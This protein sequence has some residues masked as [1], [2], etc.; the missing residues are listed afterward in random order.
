M[1]E[2]YVPVTAPRRFNGVSGT[3]YWLTPTSSEP[4]ISQDQPNPIIA[5]LVDGAVSAANDK[6]NGMAKGGFNFGAGVWNWV[7]TPGGP[8]GELLGVKNPVS[9]RYYGYSNAKEAGWS[10]A[11]QAGLTIGSGVGSGVFSGG[12]TSYTLAPKINDSVRVSQKGLDLVK[13]QLSRFD[14]YEP[15]EM[16]VARLEKALESG[17]RIRG[18]DRNFYMHELKEATLMNKRGLTYDVAHPMALKWDRVSP[19]SLYSPKVI[20]AF[21]KDFNDNFRVFWGIPRQ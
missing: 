14:R 7:T 10:F 16:M 3:L 12:P 8:V 5:A 11:T 17:Q 9:V 1:P 15:N 21:P 20:K 6:I 2:N 4:Y 19:F 18:A 13:N